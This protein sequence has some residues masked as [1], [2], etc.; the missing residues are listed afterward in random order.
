[1][2]E[3]Q[4]LFA[5]GAVAFVVLGAW[6]LGQSR[7]ESPLLLRNP[8]AGQPAPPRAPEAEWVP[9]DSVLRLRA[10]VDQFSRKTP[11]RPKRDEDPY[12][13][14]F[15]PVPGASL[16]EVTVV[17]R[18]DQ[19]EV[20]E[21]MCEDCALRPSD[22]APADELKQLTSYKPSQ[23]G[24]TD[25]DRLLVHEET[26]GIRRGP[27]SGCV[28]TYWWNDIK[29]HHVIRIEQPAYYLAMPERRSGYDMV[30]EWALSH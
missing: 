11:V 30:K 5:A 17:Y 25:T 21:V 24:K 28:L 23:T 3:R 12:K 14:E 22:I 15:L 10:A 13:I 6:G 19:P 20:W 2:T 16:K 4:F 18:G 9:K 8:S 29:P 26:W 27:F 1:M 7:T